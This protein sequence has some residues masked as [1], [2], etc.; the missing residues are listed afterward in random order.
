LKYIAGSIDLVISQEIP[1]ES[2]GMLVYKITTS[3]QIINPVIALN[4]HEYLNSW[5]R[6]G[7]NKI[8]RA[9]NM[10]SK[11]I[12]IKIIYWLFNTNPLG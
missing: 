9:I 2:I 4:N 3:V 6:Q 12:K 5:I 7:N 10:G 8:T 1:E 11:A